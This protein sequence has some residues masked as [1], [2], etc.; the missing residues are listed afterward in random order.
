[1]TDQD[2]LNEGFSGQD[3]P[4]PCPG[5]ATSFARCFDNDDGREVLSHLENLTLKRACGPAI[6]SEALW[7]LEGQRYLLRLVFSLIQRGKA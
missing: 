4:C 1:M 3:P 6:T 7:H 5:L 2:V